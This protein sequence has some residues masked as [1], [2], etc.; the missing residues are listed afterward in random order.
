MISPAIKGTAYTLL[1]SG[2]VAVLIHTFSYYTNYSG[3]LATYDTD[4]SG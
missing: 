2:I 3:I 4:Y 1:T